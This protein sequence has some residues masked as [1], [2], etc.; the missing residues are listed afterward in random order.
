MG[1]VNLGSTPYHERLFFVWLAAG[2]HGELEAAFAI[3]GRDYADEESARAAVLDALEQTDLRLRLGDYWPA[4]IPEN[5]KE[6][7]Y[8]PGWAEF[9]GFLDV[10]GPVY[11]W[12]R[13][14]RVPKRT[15]ARPASVPAV[16]ADPART[17]L[18]SERHFECWGQLVETFQPGQGP[19]DPVLGRRAEG[20]G[21]NGYTGEFEA[22]TRR[23]L[24]CAH[25]LED[26]ET[27]PLRDEDEFVEA[28]EDRREKL[29]RDSFH[30]RH[31]KPEIFA[32]YQRAAREGRTL[33]AR[34][35]TY[36]LWREAQARRAYFLVDGEPVRV[37]LAADGDPA[38]AW[39]LDMATGRIVATG[40]DDAQAVFGG[41]GRRVTEHVW[42]LAVEE[43]RRTLAV[44]GA[45]AEAYAR[46]AAEPDEVY[47]RRILTR[48][49]DLWAEKFAGESEGGA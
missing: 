33:A 19:Y 5:E 44:D 1:S 23:A 38:Q 18:Y 11:P 4:N 22:D 6:L 36:R 28:V 35:E 26:D 37:D 48:S 17:A 31:D 10:Y 49:F 16:T 20:Y 12:R 32:A 21:L 25:G 27:W 9:R 15:A 14:K 47:R 42:L 46:A 34:R 39:R 30:Q 40:R 24:Q 8:W 43:R 41:P 13:P 45:I 29:L 2:V 3:D 7:D